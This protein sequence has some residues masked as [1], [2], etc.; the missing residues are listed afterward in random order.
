MSALVVAAALGMTAVRAQ[1]AL[2]AQRV[3]LYDDHANARADIAA[4]LKQ[5]R[6]EHKRVLVDFGGDWCGDC[7][8]LHAVLIQ[9]QNA[10]I[11][12][13]HYIEVHVSVGATGIE[14]NQAI[15]EG[16]GIPVRH[17][18]PAV[19][20]LSADGKVVTSSR[21]KEFET[22]AATNPAGVTAF[23]NHWKG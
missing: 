17:G 12:Q 1:V 22:V 18:V 13:A 9:P 7:Q 3:H 15:A 11:L 16:Y 21:N 8:V 6:R 10:A 19:A 23:L 20:V 5:A 2:P 4:A 14:Q